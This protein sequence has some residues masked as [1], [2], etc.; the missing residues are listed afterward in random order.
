MKPWIPGSFFFQ[1]SI[2]Q[3]RTYVRHNSPV[4]LVNGLV[5][6]FA[7]CILCI[8]ILY[9]CLCTW[10]EWMNF[11]QSICSFCNQLLEDVFQAIH[12][13]PCSLQS[14]RKRWAFLVDT[15]KD[16]ALKI[17]FDIPSGPLQ[18]WFLHHWAERLLFSPHLLG[19]SCGTT[20]LM[21]LMERRNKL[22][23]K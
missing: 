14:V 7:M 8:L 6:V 1:S 21:Q 9:Q 20:L 16:W 2:C 4:P 13:L 5:N 11:E 17:A 3:E 19:A 22:N 12:P 18:F 15:H 23:S 10:T